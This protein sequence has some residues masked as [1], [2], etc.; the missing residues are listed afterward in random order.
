MKIVIVAF[1]I[2]IVTGGPQHFSD[3]PPSNPFYAYIQTAFSDNLIGGY[4]D[5]TF[6][7]NDNI[8]RAQVAKV[9]VLASGEDLYIPATATF[10]DVPVGSAFFMFVETAYANGML[11][12][13]AD[14]TFHPNDEAT[15]GEISKIVNLGT[16]P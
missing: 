14:H 16:H 6:R 9:A 8:T 3:V 7:P 5:G 2:P 10:S 13:Y 12:G 15:R 4:S 11:N 1:G